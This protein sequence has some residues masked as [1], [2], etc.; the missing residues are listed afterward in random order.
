[1]PTTSS[2]IETSSSSY[3]PPLTRYEPHGRIDIGDDELP[4]S[5]AMNSEQLR[6]LA[7][8]W[9]AIQDPDDIARARRIARALDWLA[10]YREPPPRTPMEELG[11][12][13]SGWMGL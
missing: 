4:Q 1:M 6:E 2:P 3:A 7:A 10:E 12:R 9:R 8:Q 11:A 5:L 13:I